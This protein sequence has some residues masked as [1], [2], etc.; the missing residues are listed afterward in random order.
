[1]TREWLGQKMSPWGS[2]FSYGQDSGSVGAVGSFYFGLRRGEGKPYP[3]KKYVEQAIAAVEKW[4]PMAERG[5]RG[6]TKRDA[7]ELRTIARGL[8]YFL[9]VDYK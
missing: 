8:R 7:A 3:D 4:E 6:W 9:R 2:D 1:M 5:E